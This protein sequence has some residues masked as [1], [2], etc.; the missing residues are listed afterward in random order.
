MESP[1]PVCDQWFATHQIQH[2]LYCITEAH[3]WWWNRANLWLIKGRDQDL[4]IDTGLGVASLR[5]YIANLIDKP[6]L[7]V[8][9]HI[10]YDHAGGLHEFDHRAIHVHEAV[11]LAE[12]DNH[13]ALCDHG[14]LEEHF[15]QLP[16][17]GF[18]VE[19]YAMKPTQPTQILQ[20]GDVID[21]GNR[22]FEVMHL[23]G[24]SPGCIALYDPK[25]R[26]LF[27]GDIVYDGDL[28]DELYG[29]DIPTYISTYERLQQV[30]VETVHPGHYRS[31]GQE[32]LNEILAEYL[33]FRRQPGCP[34]DAKHP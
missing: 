32:R 15:E 25:S 12:G 11:A 19:Q 17:P 4:L 2:D 7:A 6:L 31:F 3:Y 8:A 30:K 1:K 22:S 14:V 33:A 21:L 5:K 27:S 26:E 28:L 9:S 34:S 23:P 20:A 29:S 16:Y 24:H 10:H 13:A 18:C